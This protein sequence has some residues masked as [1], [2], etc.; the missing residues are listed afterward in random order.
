M[1]PYCKKCRLSLDT[2]AVS[3]NRRFAEVF[4]LTRFLQACTNP[5][6]CTARLMVLP[7][8]GKPSTLGAVSRLLLYVK[9]YQHANDIDTMERR[10]QAQLPTC[11]GTMPDQY[12]S[13]GC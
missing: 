11:K 5:A 13:F 4:T 7:T 1:S 9:A 6:P 10:R 8:S 12:V 3:K 2:F